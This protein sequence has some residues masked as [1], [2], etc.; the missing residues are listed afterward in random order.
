MAL[1]KDDF[2]PSQDRRRDGLAAQNRQADKPLLT[3]FL[4]HDMSKHDM[5]ACRSDSTGTVANSVAPGR[6]LPE[7]A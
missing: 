4:K 1:D 6:H 2:R 7:L 3:R 5:S